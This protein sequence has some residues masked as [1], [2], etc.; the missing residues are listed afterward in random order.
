VQ[1]KSARGVTKRGSAQQFRAYPEAVLIHDADADPYLPDLGS[2]LRNPSPLERREDDFSRSSEDSSKEAAGKH[3][4]CM[5]GVENL[6][7]PEPNDNT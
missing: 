6:D 3:H 5:P 1:P 2:S 4:V 7:S